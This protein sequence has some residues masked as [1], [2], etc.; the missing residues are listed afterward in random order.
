M[1]VL[2]IIGGMA[3]AAG[4]GPAAAQSFET[5]V[6]T[7]PAGPPEAAAVPQAKH[8]Q[9]PRKRAAEKLPGTVAQSARLTA[10]AGRTTFTVAL[11]EGVTAEVF[12]L[13]EPYRVVIDLPDVLFRLPPGTGKAGTGL[14]SA[15][16]FGLLAD[17]RARLVLDATGPVSIEKAEMTARQGKAV[18]L[19]VT[20][21]PTDATSFGQGTGAQRRASDAK[22]SVFD[23]TIAADRSQPRTKP[24]VIIDPGHGGIDPGALGASNLY[25]K[26]VALAVGRELGAALKASGRYDVHMTRSTDVF[27]S[28]EQ[29]LKMSRQHAADL[30]ISIHADAI[31]AKSVASRVRGA[32]VYTLSERASDEQA[33]L[34]AEKENASDIVAGFDKIEGE[35]KDEV[36]NILIDLLKRETSNFSADFAHVLV[37]RLGK[38]LALSKDPQRS[39]A[40]K[41]LKQPDSPSVLV[42]LG[43]MSNADDEKLMG[44]AEWQRKV[45]GSISAAVD[46]YFSKHTAKTP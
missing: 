18:D 43:Y 28:L 2:A 4:P 44:S 3:V 32:T 15:F 8:R 19:V 27:V 30:F 21:K 35:N 42:E 26:H 36:R 45:A 10:A 14:I 33:R 9:S 11:S 12:T 34:M 37:K 16:R 17:R 39:A 13:A 7:A 41:V 23:D 25:E 24:V 20:L 22:A 31:D 38:A 5:R 29:R 46:A 1:L 6:E 40:F